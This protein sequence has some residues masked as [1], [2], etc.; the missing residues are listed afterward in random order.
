[1]V[2][3]VDHK[4]DDQGCQSFYD[5][6]DIDLGEEGATLC[7]EDPD[8]VGFNT[9]VWGGKAWTCPKTNLEPLVATP[10]EKSFCLYTKEIEAS[11][12]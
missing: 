1:M 11:A 6:E 8:C 10:L 2:A 12:K 9:W 4:G 7:D 3:G 5:D